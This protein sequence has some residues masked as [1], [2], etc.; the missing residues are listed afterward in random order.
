M[1]TATATSKQ[2]RRVSR[3]KDRN[4]QVVSFVPCHTLNSASRDPDVQLM[5][6]VQRDEPEAF[7]TLINSYWS[8][9]FGHFFRQLGDR[10]EAEDLAQEV[11]LRLY[12]HRKRYQPRAKFAT[13]L[14]HITQNVARNA[15]RSRRRRPMI[16]LGALREEDDSGIS[17]EH[18]FRD[19]G[20]APWQPMERAE[21]TGAVRAAVSG[22][23]NRQRTAMELH[24][25]HDLTYAEIAV[26]LKM[27]PKAIKSL[28]YRARNHLRES[29]TMLVDAG[30]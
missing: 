5:L 20:E 14:Y 29:L 27:T 7:E 21:L 16:R 3:T 19:R 24:Q 25:F 26:E 9:I 18:L 15:L 17:A 10:Q 22:L 13:W 4:G 1:A 8:R 23:A 28:L 30:G 6:A 2:P 12:R 11:F